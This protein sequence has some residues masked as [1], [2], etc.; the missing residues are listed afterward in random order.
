MVAASD[1]KE[2]FSA[3]AAAACLLVAVFSVSAGAFFAE[4]TTLLSRERIDIPP[5]ALA[6][7]AQGILKQLGY[8][9]PPHSTAYGFL[10]CNLNYFGE[11][12]MRSTRPKARQ[13]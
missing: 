5:E 2:G 4:G 6:F 1:E 10:C 13:V 7:E 11:P 12:A 9:D 8:A 3:R